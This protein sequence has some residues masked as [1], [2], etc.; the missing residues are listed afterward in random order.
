MTNKQTHFKNIVVKFPI[1]KEDNIC[2]FCRIILINETFLVYPA[3][4]NN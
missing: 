4:Q 2:E 1:L 3:Y